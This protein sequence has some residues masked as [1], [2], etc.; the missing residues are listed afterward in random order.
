MN[1]IIIDW[2][3]PKLNKLPNDYFKNLEDKRQRKVSRITV[4]IIKDK[5]SCEE[6]ANFELKKLGIEKARRDRQLHIAEWYRNVCFTTITIP[7]ISIA[8][9]GLTLATTRAVYPNTVKQYIVF[10]MI[11]ISITYVLLNAIIGFKA[12]QK[13]ISPKAYSQEPEPVDC[14]GAKDYII[15]AAERS[16]VE[17]EWSNITNSIISNRKLAA[18][19]LDNVFAG[20]IIMIIV[21]AAYATTINVDGTPEN[22]PQASIEFNMF[23]EISNVNNSNTLNV[24]VY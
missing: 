18:K 2:I 15:L 5:N 12:A 22:S 1:S 24:K 17:L 3:W 4:A 8:V 7:F 20:I 9:T 13:A 10:G 6:W 23:N 19:A 11:I 14:Q 21:I 16:K